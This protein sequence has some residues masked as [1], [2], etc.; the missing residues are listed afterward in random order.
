MA[1]LERVK[2][3]FQVQGSGLSSRGAPLRHTGV[4]ASL[5]DLVEKDDQL[6]A[7]QHMAAGGMAGATSTTLTYPLDLLRARRTVDFR[8]DVPMGFYTALTSILQEVGARG[9]FRGLLPSLCGII[10]YIGIDF[11]LFDMA[12]RHCRQNEYGLDPSGDLRPLTK[13]LP[14][15]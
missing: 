15:S 14:L 9:L 3:L 10:P 1:P 5:V 12:K 6:A 4:F 8:G 7:W 2:I 13:V 11:A